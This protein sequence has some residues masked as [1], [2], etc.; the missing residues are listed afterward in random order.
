MIANLEALAALSQLGTMTRAAIRLRIT[1]SA[2]S[3]RIAALE[4]EVQ[5]KLIERTGRR[6]HLTAEGRDL[7]ARTQPLL[8]ELRASLTTGQ[9]ERDGTLVVGVSESI[10]SSWGP[11]TL[12]GV[13]R[14]LQG[15]EVILNSHRSPVALDYVR[16][17][18]Y[19]L[20]LV[21]GQAGKYADLADEALCEEPMVIVPGDGKGFRWRSGQRLE[22]MSIEPQ[23]ETWRVIRPQLVALEAERNIRIE[24]TQVL[25]SYAS[26]VQMARAGF[27]HGL[28]PEGIARALGAR[29]MVR[30]PRPG[31]TRPISLV[32][33]P[34]MFQRPV[35][36]RFTEELA[37][38][39]ARR[40][41][42]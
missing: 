20:A 10:L 29:T 11:A 41:N 21:G 42:S 22:V 27:A 15:L 9:L 8:A 1:Q 25:Q 28:V 17:G 18:D 37:A 16:S 5:A 23:S 14:K 33:R 4:Q 38:A 24:A 36:R 35:V 26:I 13:Q 40:W 12:A 30:L 7:L 19:M 31:V 2:V 32:G 34:F 39:C 3:K 6:V